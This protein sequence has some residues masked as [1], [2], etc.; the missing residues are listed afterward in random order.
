M[1][2]PRICPKCGF[3]YGSVWKTCQGCNVNL[4]NAG[5]FTILNIARDIAVA[6]FLVAAFLVFLYATQP[7]QR[8]LYIRSMHELLEGDCKNAGKNFADAFKANVIH[9]AA[10]SANSKLRER[11][12]KKIQPKAAAKDPQESEAGDPAGLN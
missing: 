9:K 3:L 4:V 2:Y 5:L 1:K 6:V 7:E 10:S 12:R 11:L 8:T